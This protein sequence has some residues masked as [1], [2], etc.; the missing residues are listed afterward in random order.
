ML[1][2]SRPL[3][4]DRAVA[5]VLTELGDIEKRQMD[6]PFLPVEASLQHDGVDVRVDPGEVAHLPR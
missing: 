3:R 2:A 5:E 1:C 4:G 6:E